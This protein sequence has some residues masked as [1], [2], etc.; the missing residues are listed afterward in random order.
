M[1]RQLKSDRL[2]KIFIGDENEPFLVQERLLTN[3]SEYFAKALKHEQSL[4]SEPG[5][6]RFPEDGPVLQPWGVMLFW[7]V[8]KRL[9]FDPLKT[10]HLVLC[11]NAWILGDKYLMPRFQNDIMTKFMTHFRRKALPVDKD[12]VNMLLRLSPAEEVIFIMYGAVFSV[13]GRMKSSELTRAVVGL[14]FRF[15][16]HTTRTRRKEIICDGTLLCGWAGAPCESI[17][18]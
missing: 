10:K 12:L 2:I 15:S 3:A 13:E 1:N 7:L 8:H 9:P 5:I 17:W 14:W 16:M 18:W 4:G 6:L 11:V